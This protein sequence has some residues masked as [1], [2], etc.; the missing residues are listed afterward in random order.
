MCIFGKIK[1]VKFVKMSN[2]NDIEIIYDNVECSLD[3]FGLDVENTY[4][5]LTKF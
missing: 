4:L 2:L 5:P 1:A 3:K